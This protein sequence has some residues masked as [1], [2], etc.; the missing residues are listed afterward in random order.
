VRV[1]QRPDEQ[2]VSVYLHGRYIDAGN[3]YAAR[4]VFR[5]GGVM[6][7]GLEKTVAGV[8]S[9]VAPPEVQTD[10]DF[11][12]MPL[13]VGEWYWF[14]FQVRG[15]VVRAGAWKDEWYGWTVQEVDED[16]SAAGRVGIGAGVPA[17]NR[18]T[19]LWVD[20]DRFEVKTPAADFDIRVELRVTG[21]IWGVGVERYSTLNPN[22]ISSGWDVFWD[23]GS[24][25]WEV[26]DAGV[27]Y[28]CI[29]SDALGTVVRQRRWLR[30]TYTH[31]A[32]DGLS[33]IDLYT[34]LDGV[35]WVSIHSASDVAEPID[36]DPGFFSIYLQGA[37]TVSQVEI[38]NGADGPLVVSPDFEAQAPGTK[39]FVDAPGSTW[40][41]G[42]AG[43]CASA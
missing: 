14:R 40:V 32:G 17:G 38:R 31:N 23:Y 12:P 18:N 3:H 19:N 13:V 42:G 29:P 33:R 34:S 5:P 28:D 10:N 7:V 37:V 1:S 30:G 4:L 22:Y 8:S 21:E 6:A 26:F 11:V 9:V 27:F 43:I 36:L 20:V 15:Q 39:E 2:P 25:C 24:V 35:N 16:L 41:V